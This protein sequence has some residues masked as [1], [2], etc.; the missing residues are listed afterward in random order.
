MKKLI[1]ALAVATLA[2]SAFFV[3]HTHA[4]FADQR[5]FTVYNES[6]VTITHLYISPADA[7]DWG[8]DQISDDVVPGDYITI[9]FQPRDAYGT[10]L[11]DVRIDASDGTTTK[12]WNVNFCRTHSVD[13][14]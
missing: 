2:V 6:S 7:D 3:A 12:K 5:D 11:F 14:T 1:A 8:Y 10:C 9:H 13:F 4:T